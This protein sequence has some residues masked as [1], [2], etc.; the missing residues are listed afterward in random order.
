[1]HSLQTDER[2]RISAHAGR[3]WSAWQCF[4]WANC[5]ALFAVAI[6]FRLWKLGT[7]TG[8]NGD[9][10][11][12]G[13]YAIQFLRG[14]AIPLRTN[15]GNPL[16]V[17]FFLP[18]VV[19]HALWS[20]SF[21]L[22]RVPALF[23]G[24]LALVPN[25]WL[26]RRVFGVRTAAISTVLLAVLPINIAYS[27]IGW[28]TSQ[29]LLATVFVCYF[30]LLAVV[31]QANA[32][33]WLTLAVIATAAAILVHPTNV[34][35]IPLVVVAALYERRDQ[36]RDWLEPRRDRRRW[37]FAWLAIG[38]AALAITWVGRHG[39][40]IGS[41]QL[42]DVT[43][44]GLFARNY[45]R[46]F[47]GVTVYRYLAG[48][49][50]AAG[51]ASGWLGIDLGLLDVAGFLAM[52][53]TCIGLFAAFRAHFGPAERVL[54]V[55][56]AISAVGYFLVAG[57]FAIEPHWERYGLCLILPGVLIASVTIAWFFG[58]MGRIKPHAQAV[59][60]MAAWAFLLSFHANYFGYIEKTGGLS[61]N[62]LRTAEVEP[63]ELALG[64]ILAR[65]DNSKPLWIVTS[66]WWTYWPI[67]YLAMPEEDVRVED[68]SVVCDRDDFR[69]AVAS[70]DVWFVEFSNSE[71]LPAVKRYLNEQQAS[72]REETLFDYGGRPVIEILGPAT[73]G[74]NREVAVR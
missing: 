18:Q 29:T 39:M 26:C 22:V 24:L 48:S 16:N 36:V 70:G 1:M 5:I 65:R 14:E 49:Q 66:E 32:K 19:L 23:S 15:T 4:I 17:F 20:P 27:R 10:A 33:R 44:A 46:L 35:L 21:S 41:Q 71:T 58:R 43:E 13:V 47:S 25:W 37:M 69:E 42:P 38:V 11:Q 55:G 31:E 63:K 7:I 73:G 54:V 3:P 57:P 72:L 50:L 34:F 62:T 53:V 45:V 61:H 40:G 30:S 2:N 74:T 28:D 67:R 8:M 12:Y 59:V 6:F 51:G 68:W 64:H 56:S 52:G 9:E 60:I